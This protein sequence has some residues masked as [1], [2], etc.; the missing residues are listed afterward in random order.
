MVILVV[1][2]FVLFYVCWIE[3]ISVVYGMMVFVGFGVGININFGLL[4]GL[5]YFLY[6]IVVIICIVMFVVFFGGMIVLIIML[7]VFNNRSG[8]NYVDFKM[9]EFCGDLLFWF[10]LCG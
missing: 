6:M 3:K 2:I 8:I 4:Y 9:G 10:L 5:V 1:V 7:I